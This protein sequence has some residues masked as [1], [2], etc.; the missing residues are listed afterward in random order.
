MAAS[1]NTK[2]T[3]DEKK[4]PVV[5]IAGPTASGKSAL[6]VDVAQAFDGV[7]INADSM[8]VYR[9][10]RVIT[11]RPSAAEEASAPHRLYGVL[12][13]GT[14]CSAGR[15]VEMAKAEIEAAWGSDKLPVVVGG[16]GLYLKAL[17]E[18]LSD[19]PDVPAETRAEATEMLARPYR[20][21]WVHPD[22]KKV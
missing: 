4:K 17:M 12:D 3:K 13:A 8:Q 1:A 6:A 18:G 2:T 16:T 9:E 20:K 7:V 22:P 11:A 19:L 14:R 10:L 5:I 15:W 21:P